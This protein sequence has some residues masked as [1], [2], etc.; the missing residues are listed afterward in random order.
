MLMP[1]ITP[2]YP[3]M[4]STYNVMAWWAGLRSSFG[5]VSHLRALG[6]NARGNHGHTQRRT[7]A[8]GLHERHQR[9]PPLRPPLPGS[10][11]ATM[12]E[13]FAA[14]TALCEDILFTPA[15]A[16]GT[17]WQRLFEPFDFFGS[18]KNFLQ[19]GCLAAARCGWSLCSLKGGGPTCMALL[20]V[21]LWL[22]C[23]AIGR[24]SHCCKG[25]GLTR[26]ARKKAEQGFRP[27]LLRSV[28]PLVSPS[29]S[30][31]HFVPFP[32]GGG[33]RAYQGGLQAVGRLGALA[34]AHPGRPHRGLCDRQVGPFSL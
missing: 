26:M 4:N 20:Q 17:Q 34:P 6:P 15:G 1:I 22:P 9:S 32:L 11:L 28:H 8:K 31:L 30:C 3:A 5:L 25:G 7:T 33:H 16:K 21:G 13:E 10:T 23:A 27:P 29:P 12:T 14:A 2:A 18:F 19:V 24:Y